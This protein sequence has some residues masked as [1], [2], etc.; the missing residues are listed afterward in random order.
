RQRRLMDLDGYRRALIGCRH[1]GGLCRDVRVPLIDL[2]TD[3]AQ[4]LRRA[5]E[6]MPTWRRFAQRVDLRLDV[7]AIGWE[8]A[9]K[10]ADLRGD[11]PSDGNDD[12]E[13]QRDGGEHCRDVW[14]VE[15]SQPPD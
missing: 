8:A 6:E 7:V 13:G 15:L 5:L 10:V 4:H 9:G 12:H 11:D 3:V 14:K 1:A 2:A